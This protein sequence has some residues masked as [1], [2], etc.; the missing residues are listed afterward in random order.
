MQGCGGFLSQ[1]EAQGFFDY[2]FDDLGDV[3][4]LDTNED[5]IP[6]NAGDLFCCRWEAQSQAQ[7]YETTIAGV[8]DGVVVGCGSFE[9]QQQ[10]QQWFE[11][12]RDF[13]EGVDGNGDGIACSEGLD[14]CCPEAWGGWE[15]SATT[16]ATAGVLN[17]TFA[18]CGSFLTPNDAQ[19]WFDANPDFG[20]SVD[21]NGDGT[22][23][24]DGDIGGATDCSKRF[25]ELVLPQFCPPQPAPPEPIIVAIVDGKAVTLTTYPLPTG[26]P[27]G[28]ELSAAPDESDEDL[29][30]IPQLPGSRTGGYHSTG[31]PVDFDNLQPDQNVRLATI[32][33]DWD[34]Y[35]GD[36]ANLP[37]KH[38]QVQIIVSSIDAVLCKFGVEV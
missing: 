24:G 15:E 27:V 32:P 11:A 7:G 28:L 2:Y 20:E 23:C 1:Q 34:D 12:N 21:G 5:G 22:A 30:R 26:Q 16:T 10:A 6:C 13:G 9:S 17:G 37:A 35:E 14:E 38:E 3:S 19:T 18:T 36:P 33:V 8:P 29:C 25:P 4:E 31:F